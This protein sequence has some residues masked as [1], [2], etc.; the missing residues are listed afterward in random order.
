VLGDY[1]VAQAEA[2]AEVLQIFDSWAGV[3]SPDDYRRF[4]LPH[5]RRLFQRLAPLGV[6]L[7]HFG[8]NTAT[9]L[10]LLVDA[11][12]DVIGLD[13]RLPLDEGWARI[14]PRAVQGNLDP[15][16]LFAPR[17]ELTSQVNDI[18]RRAGGRAGHIFNLGHGILPGT[19]VDQVRAVVDLV[20][21]RTA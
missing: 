18:L 17:A 11:G 13:W 12:G 19:P 3:L 5:S 14:G 15:T 21:D 4:V 7:I 20:H 16:A 9:L 6:P 8:V 1:L 10:P 2:G